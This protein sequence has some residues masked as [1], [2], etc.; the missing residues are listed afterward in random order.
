MTDHS[1]C[2]LSCR[3][4]GDILNPSPQQLAK[5]AAEL[6]QENLSGMTEADYAEHPGAYLRYGLDEGPLYTIDGYRDG[7]AVLSKYA[8]PDF[9]ELVH[10]V[11]LGEVTEQQLLMLWAWLSEGRLDNIRTAHPEC[12][13]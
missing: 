10:E 9:E 11:T 8:D 13:W 2:I 7:T 1:W 6:H 12:K 4:G 5:A 3:Y